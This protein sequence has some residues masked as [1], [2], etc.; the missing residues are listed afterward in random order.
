MVNTVT[1]KNLS[2][3]YRFIL[4]KKK[5]VRDINKWKRDINKF[6]DRKLR[7]LIGLM[8]ELGV[9]DKKYIETFNDLR[10]LNAIN[11]IIN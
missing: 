5:I 11:K 1:D 3:E 7:K 10:K 2:K 6:S 4:L 9:D 8:K